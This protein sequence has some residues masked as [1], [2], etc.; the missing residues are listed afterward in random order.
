MDEWEFSTRL[1]FEPSEARALRSQIVAGAP[2]LTNT[3]TPNGA[4][5]TSTT[6]TGTTTFTTDLTDELVSATLENGSTV[7][8]TN[9]TK[10]NR[11]SRT[12][13]GVTQATWSWDDLSSL[14]VRTGEYDQTGSLTT[15]WLTDPTST[16]GTVLAESSGGVSSWLLSDPPANVT[17][18]VAT[19][20]S[21][22]TGTRALD[23][24]GNARTA[25]T[26]SLATQQS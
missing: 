1:G 3:W 18:A 16:I 17:A 20:G 23:A 5:A 2:T 10:G 9:D 14:P 24:F 11:T 13:G 12:V 22:V 8:Y 15:A 26:G 21:T 6:P 25:A 4:L 7:S 19:T